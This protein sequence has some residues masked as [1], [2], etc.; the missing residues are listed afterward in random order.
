MIFFFLFFFHHI[1]LS[2][3]GSLEMVV[4]SEE[5][6]EIHANLLLFDTFSSQKPFAVSGFSCCCVTL[7]LGTIVEI[8]CILFIMET[9]Q[10]R[11]GIYNCVLSVG[12]ILV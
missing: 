12:I 7:S 5:E 11:V 3:L 2:A 10:E 9:R 6:R 4:N 1:S 8:I